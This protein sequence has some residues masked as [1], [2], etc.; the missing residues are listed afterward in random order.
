MLRL[1]E[2]KAPRAVHKRG[3]RVEAGDPL[4]AIQHSNRF[5]SLY[6]IW[7]YSNRESAE[8]MLRRLEDGPRNDVDRG[9]NW[10]RN[11]DQLSVTGIAPEKLQ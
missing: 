1:I 10:R 11:L 6:W 7:A 5:V 4:Y 8:I 9:A 2:F 3:T